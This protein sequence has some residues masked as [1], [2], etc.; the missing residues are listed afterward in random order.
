MA[1]LSQ[2]TS[3][4]VS[5]K[6]Q[7]IRGALTSRCS[8]GALRIATR[9]CA[10][11]PD[12]HQVILFSGLT[13]RNPVG[14][15]AFESAIALAMME[16]GEV[17]L[18]DADVNKPFLGDLLKSESK[19]RKL[20]KFGPAGL[21]QL[22]SGDAELSEVVLSGSIPNLNFLTAGDRIEP[23][24]FLGEPCEAL[25]KSLREQYEFVVVAGAPVNVSPETM[26]L[27]VHCDAV[28]AVV[29]AGKQSQKEIRQLS[30]EL[31]DLSIPLLGVILANR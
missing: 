14:S 31:A 5:T 26:R 6:S 12:Q 2:V 11:L 20:G 8:D 4:P 9:I 28:A 27:A 3:K 15:T 24:L 13:K 16:Q 7:S 25:I 22:L 17:L 23:A 21:A 30:S 19:G 29:S 1:Q 18:V 10:N